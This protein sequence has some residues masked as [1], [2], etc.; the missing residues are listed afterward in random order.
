M[1]PTYDRERTRTRRGAE[2][3]SVS[4]RH[5]GGQEGHACGRVP[6]GTP[7]RIAQVGYPHPPCDSRLIGELLFQQS[8]KRSVVTTKLGKKKRI[9]LNLI[10]DT[11]FLID[12]AGPVTR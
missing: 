2:S 1:G 5:Y 8:P 6:T 3:Q 7:S 4:T 12:T 9:F 10:N 11:M